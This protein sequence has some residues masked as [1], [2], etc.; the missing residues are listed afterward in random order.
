M[1]LQRADL[2]GCAVFILI[3]L[4][5]CGNDDRDE[6]AAGSIVSPVATIDPNS[7]EP[8]VLPTVSVDARDPEPHSNGE[9]V[10]YS[11]SFDDEA[12]KLFFVGETSFGARATIVDGRYRVEVE[13]GEWQSITPGP[14]LHPQ[15][16]VIEA[17]VTLNGTGFGGLVAR[18][19]TDAGGNDW[20]YVCLIDESGWAGCVATRGADYEDLFFE[21]IDDF[22]PGAVQ[23]VVLTVVDD[24]IELA[25]NG[26]VIGSAQDSSVQIGSWGV[27]AESQDESLTTVEFDNLSI[28]IVPPG[29]NP[30]NAPRDG[31]RQSTRI[32]KARGTDRIVRT[33]TNG[34][35]YQRDM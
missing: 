8:P 2:V 10:L 34:Q 1:F 20:M 4:T 35:K 23:R 22:T 33:S 31:G 11:T 27:F 14:L 3:A 21:Q 32:V 13:D 15:N 18:S 16:G 19:S 6:R 25:V 24:R 17:D 5:A 28:S 30:F 12:G 7:I 9:N 26:Q 29:S